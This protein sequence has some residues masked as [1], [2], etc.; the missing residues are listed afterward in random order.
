MSVAAAIVLSAV[1]AASQ[2][3][4]VSTSTRP[5]SVAFYYGPSVPPDLP[6]SFDWLVVEADYLQSPQAIEARGTK[7]F[8]Y[9]SVGEVARSRTIH[10]DVKKEW[11]LA[12]NDAW[13][14]RV[15]DLT[16]P[17]WRQ[18]FE[19]VW[20]GALWKRGFRR[21]FLDTLDSFDLA[22]LDP[23]R[24]KAQV[25]ALRGIVKGLSDRYPGIELILNRGFDILPDVKKLVA[26]VVVESLFDSYDAGKKEY[27]SVSASSREWLLARLGEVRKLGVPGIVIDYRPLHEREEARRTAKKIADLGFIPYVAN[28]ELDAV[29]IGLVEA[30]P[31]RILAVYDG[32]EA[33][34]DLAYSTVH[35]RLA[36]PLEYLGYILDY[37]DLRGTLPTVPLLGRYAG[38]VTWLT[39]D[40][41]GDRI[42]Y[43]DF[44]LR[45]IR[46]GVPV[47]ILG[48]LGFEADAPFRDATGM[49]FGERTLKE[50]VS[51]LEAD[52]MVGFETE[53]RARLEDAV[54]LTAGGRNVS[55]HLVVGDAQGVKMDAVFTA[56]WGGYVASRYLL[57]KGYE[58][59][60]MWILNPFEFMRRALRLQAM[61]ILDATTENGRRIAIAHIDG[62]GFASRAEM[63]GTPYGGE[64]IRKEILER[65]RFP[66]TVSIVEGEVGPEGLYK[67][68]SSKLESIAKRIFRLPNVEIASHGY[69]H[70]F[71][72]LEFEKSSKSEGVHLAI[73]GYEPSVKRE[74]EGS[75][76]YIEKHLSPPGKKV[77]A[78]LWTGNCLP[79]LETVRMVNAL[80][81]ANLNGGTTDITEEA[82]SLSRVS[83]IA[84]PLQSGLESGSGD[85]GVV[86]YYAPI[87]NEN[88]Y[89]NLWKGP[90][91]GFRRVIETFEMTDLPRRLK[92]LGIYYHFYSGTKVASL[93]ALHDA[94][95]F[96]LKAET[97]PLY[98]SQYARVAEGFMEARVMQ[99]VDGGWLLRGLEG[100]KTVRL[101]SELGWPDLSRSTN[102]LGVRD[103]EQ[104]RY[105]SLGPDAE[106]RLYLRED[107]P[108][109]IHLRQANGRVRRFTVLGNK[110]DLAV[111]GH[112]PLVLEIGAPKHKQCALR[113]GGRRTKGERTQGG[114][115]F[116]PSVHE[117]RDAR[118]ECL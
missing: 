111:E 80:G 60:E 48:S 79:G 44:L 5:P 9:V 116:K 20:V 61:P 40:V 18:Y 96:V 23:P 97:T 81:V 4:A 69:S 103:I 32:E 107:A 64:V 112:V 63:P 36:A 37:H 114:F 92:P 113:A 22:K 14:S 88:L 65:Y 55:H 109:Q 108:T 59:H 106:A 39:D 8:A 93:R 99:L 34:G 33:S 30:K 12:E 25:D 11:I 3:S 57:E 78:F 105:I 86:Q 77:R 110:V 28:A 42:A 10:A 83:S 38:V 117:L 16:N 2:G 98:V 51:V 84:R 102:V 47:A 74:L 66:H 58:S 91:Y 89:T 46:D 62:D 21:L 49:S 6:G 90:F 19:E 31:R 1:F 45:Q 76:R 7:V 104:G 41:G 13:A 15:L 26:A 54:E 27:G 53:V 101:P 73:P 75:I 29:G 95:A 85:V 67:E 118:I 52:S 72:W 35:Q 94:Y 82:P 50:P 56:P 87:G 24:R 100:I 71:D 17:G 43:R 68:D 115:K 70:P